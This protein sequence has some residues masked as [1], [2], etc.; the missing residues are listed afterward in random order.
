MRFGFLMYPGYEELDMIGP[1]ELATMWKAYA[2]GP[3]CV[4]VAQTTQEMRCAKGLLTRAH[5]SYAD[6]GQLDYLLIPG[7][8]ATFGEI[9]NPVTV[10][11]VRQQAKGAKAVLSVCTGTFL[12]Q[13]AGL[14]DGG[15]KVATNWKMIATLRESGVEVIEERYVQDGSIWSSAGVAAGM[16]MLLA[17][18]AHEAGPEAAWATQYQSEY[19]AEGKLYGA[20]ADWGNAP[21]YAR[22]LKAPPTT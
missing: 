12:L 19:L 1:W 5:H 4:T 22:R 18:I 8:F 17:F 3:D 7:G 9:K 13:A 15:V 14:L 20:V 6:V 10:D 16:D 2:G 21:G 11:F